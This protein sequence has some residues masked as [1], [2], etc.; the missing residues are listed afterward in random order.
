MQKKFVFKNDHWQNYPRRELEI[1]LYGTAPGSLIFRVNGKRQVK[2]FDPDRKTGVGS[3]TLDSFELAHDGS[4][5]VE[6]VQSTVPDFSFLVDLQRDYGRTIWQNETFPGEAVCRLR[7][8]P[9][10]LS[11][12]AD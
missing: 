3:V 10:D 9:A 5:T 4:L 11:Q 8:L 7:F 1:T 6:L 12:S 2:D